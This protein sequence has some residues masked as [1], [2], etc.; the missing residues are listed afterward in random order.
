VKTL[1]TTL[2]AVLVISGCSRGQSEAPS[3]S[4]AATQRSDGLTILRK[5]DHLYQAVDSR[6]FKPIRMVIRDSVSFARFLKA[7]EVDE[8][9]S[10]LRKADFRRSIV[11]VAGLGVLSTT[12]E[13]VMIDEL[14]QRRDT[15]RIVVTY[16]DYDRDL[17]SLMNA[18]QSAPLDIVLIPRTRS[19]IVFEERKVV[20]RD[21]GRTWPKPK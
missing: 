13:R 6:Q 3:P 17:C 9:G 8:D 10:R 20:S 21:C 18:A 16:V 4:S 12:A 7:A 14:R 1:T 11:A 19:T 15:L 5:E 2:L